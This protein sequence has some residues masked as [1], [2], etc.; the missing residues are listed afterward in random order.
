MQML[1]FHTDAHEHR[2][3]RGQRSSQMTHARPQQLGLKFVK[4]VPCVLCC[5]SRLSAENG[6]ADR[7]P[8]LEVNDI[9]SISDIRSTRKSVFGT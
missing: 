4:M 8:V 7:P 9:R 3:G 6:P 2:E 5:D 1:H